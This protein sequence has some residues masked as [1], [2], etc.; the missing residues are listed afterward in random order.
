MHGFNLHGRAVITL[1]S[2]IGNKDTIAD[3]VRVITDSMSNDRLRKM[4][5]AT[6]I[7]CVQPKID[8][9]LE[10]S[11]VL[12]SRAIQT[13]ALPIAWSG[14]IASTTVTTLIVKHVL[15]V[16]SFNSFSS[17]M[18][19]QIISNAF[20]GNYE[21]TGIYAAGSVVNAVAAGAVATGVGAA[22]GFAGWY[23]WKL[24]ALPQ[25]GRLLLMCTV[26]TILTMEVCF[27]LCKGRIPEAEDIK[28]ACE[29]YQ[30]RISK[31]HADVKAVL[32][33]WDT[34]N[35]F[36]FEKL[37]LA[38]AKVIDQHRYKKE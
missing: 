27:W 25:F 18:A 17:E 19:S 31:V 15:E 20:I 5:V 11:M 30:S 32:P 1:T 37:K 22:A 8:W 26:D 16:F 38:L 14:L 6:Q 23:A 36:Q 29:Q 10:H 13:T 3:V 9:A 21:S 34:W 35:A 4:F 28:L 7:C 33:V 12:Y 24:V 2:A